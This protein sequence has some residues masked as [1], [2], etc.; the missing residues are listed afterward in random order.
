M[1][2]TKD[3][4]VK[5]ERFDGP[6]EY[7]YLTLDLSFDG[8]LLVR[9]GD[10]TF[11]LEELELFIEFVRKAPLLLDN[12]LVGI[13][14]SPHRVMS[15]EEMIEIFNSVFSEATTRNLFER[16]DAFYDAITKKKT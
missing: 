5:S 1:V 16:D 10:I 12:L 9:L 15:S 6:W 14:R 4:F 13:K 11:P 8:K 3:H 2:L 7:S